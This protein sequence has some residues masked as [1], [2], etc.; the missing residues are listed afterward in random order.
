MNELSEGWRPDTLDSLPS[1]TG[2]RHC[3]VCGASTDLFWRNLD[4]HGEEV[5]VIPM[6]KVPTSTSPMAVTEAS[7][8]GESVTRHQ[9]FS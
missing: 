5:E 7:S 1:M 8:L 2:N 9:R 6:S 4:D 3:T